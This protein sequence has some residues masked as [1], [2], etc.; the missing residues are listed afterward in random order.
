MLQVAELRQETE[1]IVCTCR[2]P[3]CP[4]N[5]A[6]ENEDDETSGSEKE[7]PDLGFGSMEFIA[8]YRRGSYSSIQLNPPPI[9]YRRPL[10]HS[11]SVSLT[12]IPRV[13]L[14]RRADGTILEKDYPGWRNR[15]Y[16]PLGG[17][18]SMSHLNQLDVSLNEEQEPDCLVDQDGLTSGHDYM[19][20]RKAPE[21]RLVRNIPPER[22]LSRNVRRHFHNSTSVL[23]EQPDEGLAIARHSSDG[24]YNRQNS[25][26][27][28]TDLRLRNFAMSKRHTIT[29]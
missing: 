29:A 8:G 28:G 6:A 19:F 10:A 4:F 20:S 15:Q 17:G 22:R 21:R 25:D 3:D 5:A 1:S 26:P 14:R 13:V 18:F 23:I 9:T 27:E 7:S 2:D 11:T 24:F 12:N 16:R